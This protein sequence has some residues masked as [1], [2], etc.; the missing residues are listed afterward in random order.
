MSR[1]TI[2]SNIASLNAQR[3]FGEATNKL[4][5]SF[6]RLSSGLRINKA[7]DDAAGLSIS[8]S[9]KADARIYGQT[10][11]NLNDGISALNISESA[12]NEL[13]SIL[14]RIRE[15][16][17]QSA[18]GT[19]TSA[20][21]NA[22]NKEGQSLRQEYNRILGVTKFNGISLINGESD[23]IR[24]V[25]GGGGIDNS[26]GLGLELLNGGGDGTGLGINLDGLNDYVE[27]EDNANQEW[28]GGALTLETY[29]NISSAETG[30]AQ[31]TSKAIDGG[32]NYFYYFGWN[33]YSQTIFA[34]LGS[35]SGQAYSI[36]VS[37]TIEKDTWNHFAFTVSQ[38]KE[39]TLWLNGQN[40]GSTIHNIT[41][42]NPTLTD[43]N[44]NL[45]VG[46]VY[47]YGEGW[48]GV[49]DYSLN[50]SMDQVRVSSAVRYTENFDPSR[51]QISPDEHT[52]VLL[53]F[54]EN[55]GLFVENSAGTNDAI[56]RNGATRSDGYNPDE[57]TLAPFSLL[58]RADAL[59]TLDLMK[60]TQED[61]SL[62]LGK[63]GATQSR[64]SIA[65]NNL[66]TLKQNYISAASQITDADIAE[67]S[68]KLTANQ[69]IQQAAASVLGQANLQPRL[70][71]QLLEGI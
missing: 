3:R 1:L 63:I 48:A 65:E 40:I 36:D 57:S 46:S 53:N 26:I 44:L 64:F 13:S 33:D 21:R 62:A 50:G 4:S 67:E 30:V 45:T 12:G 58:S 31:F 61:L 70:V 10:I 14:T 16:A 66:Q 47:P 41:N 42:F 55:S 6:T 38:E 24:M 43:Y 19:N 7:V 52:T 35:I 29:A 32:G 22:L 20:Q 18:N 9:L 49:A 37:A 51:N 69:I 2:N 23:E 11:R 17:E 56:L 68:S 34:R 60:R 71:L 15:L 8:E 54:E 39:M 5:Q 59:D 25:L 27:V 28:H